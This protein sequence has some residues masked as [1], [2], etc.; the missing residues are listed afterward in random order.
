[1]EQDQILWV[2]RYVEGDMNEAEIADFEMQLANDPLLKEQL[3]TYQSAQQSLK[4]KLNEPKELQATLTGLNQK[5]FKEEAKTAILRP[6]WKWLGAVAAVLVVGLF[7]WAPWNNNLYEDYVDDS[8]FLVTER[9]DA[10][11]TDL[12][13]AASL[14]NENN[15]EAANNLL[16]QLHAKQPTDAMI[17]YYYGLSLLKSNYTTEAR[18]ILKPI[19]DGESVFKYESAYAIALSYLK[20]D[21]KVDCKV[22][23]QKI[24]SGTT[25]YEQAKALLGKL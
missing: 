11:P 2:A 13:K 19:Y 5:Y 21:N 20:E 8:Q 14:Y 10:L 15:Y 17:S 22:W 24:P 23:L 18:T 4:M 6:A 25:R 3:T 7:I 12:D 16:S 1:M 9:S